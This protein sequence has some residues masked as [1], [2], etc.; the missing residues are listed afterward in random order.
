VL[1]LLARLGRAILASLPDLVTA[2]VILFLGR[3]VA[4]F[5][6]TV[7]QRVEEGTAS[8]PGVYP[9]TAGATR[10]LLVGAVWLVTVAAAYPYLPGSSSEAFKAL[11]LVVG[12]GLSLGSTGIV[13]QAMS[14]VGVI[15]PGRFPGD[16]VRSAI[17]G[18]VTEVLPPGP[19]HPG[20]EVTIPNTVAGTAR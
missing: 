2:V 17:E 19:H 9:E 7:V 4:G 18:V 1:G 14:G 8:L 5:V 20:E 11:S 13:A 3:A 6:S 15:Y 16:C 10:R 12:L